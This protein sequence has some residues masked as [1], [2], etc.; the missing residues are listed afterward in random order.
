[1]HAEKHTESIQ[2]SNHLIFSKLSEK[3]IDSDPCLEIKSS[4][5]S[6][7][8]HSPESLDKKKERKLDID[9][10]SP[11]RKNFKRWFPLRP[12]NNSTN[13]NTLVEFHEY[14]RGLLTKNS[15]K[16][17]IFRFIWM[18]IKQYSSVCLLVLFVTT[19]LEIQYTHAKLL[20]R[21]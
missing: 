19:M 12:N 16:L 4:F 9:Q 15:D 14:K 20:D 11:S 2:K 8:I 7:E 21:M 17:G 6:G 10:N 5:E 18:K 3:K 13:F 1:M